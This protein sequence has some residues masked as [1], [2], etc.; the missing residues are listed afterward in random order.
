MT[1]SVVTLDDKYSL[2][3]G[4][5]FLS[6]NQ[7]L[8]RLPMDQARR[9]RAAGL[10]TTGYISGYRGSPL[11]VYDA[12][13]WAAQEQLDAFDIRFVPGLNEELAATAVRGSQELA[14]FGKSEYEGVYGLWYGK[15]LGVDRACEALK[16]GNLEGAA[17]KGGVLVVAGDDHGGKSSASAHQSEHTLMAGF[18]PVLYP[19]TTDEI[20]EYGLYGWE[21]SRFSGAYAGLKCITDTLDLTASIELPDLFRQFARPELKV[22]AAGLNIRYTPAPLE[23]EAL[24]VEHRLPAVQAFVRANPLDRVM[25]APQRRML[26]LVAAGKAYLDLR[27]ALGDLGLDEARC[28]ALGIGLYKPALIWPLEPEAAKKFA[29]GYR[30]LLAIEEKRPVVEDQLARLLYGLDAD[31]RPAIAGKRSLQG[32][33]LISEVGELN[34]A[35]IRKALMIKVAIELARSLVRHASSAYAARSDGWQT[36]AVQARLL[37]DAAFRAMGEDAVQLHGGV[38]FTW[39]YNCHLFLKRALANEIVGTSAENRADLVAGDVVERAARAG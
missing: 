23:L 38:G 26:G 28:L 19:A 1:K 13:L 18:I 31:K 36:L 12:A 39:E 7:A 35:S 33:P 2:T 24:T 16:L 4:R 6:S 29:A 11:G 25:I 10:K 14:W 17:A 30:S 8:V 22:P 15:G 9:D 34:P 21:M 27:Q 5:V 32:A 3:S 37:A 20:I